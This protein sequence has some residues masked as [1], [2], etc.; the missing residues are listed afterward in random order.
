MISSSGIFES[1]VQ[2]PLQMMPKEIQ[3]FS[4]QQ[5]SK[6]PDLVNRFL[7]GHQILN[8]MKEYL[9]YVERTIATL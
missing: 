3:Y 5:S 9:L 2:P 8:L 6:H 4:L 7:Q 1:S